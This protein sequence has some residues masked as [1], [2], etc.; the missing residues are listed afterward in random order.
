MAADIMCPQ[1]AR[2]GCGG[3]PPSRGRPAA[4]RT[5]GDFQCRSINTCSSP[6]ASLRDL[7][8]DRPSG[9]R[10]PSA[11]TRLAGKLHFPNA[12]AI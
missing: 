5:S 6:T 12:V 1:H 8:L 11:A 2:A 9:K 10:G 7:D 3:E 4:P